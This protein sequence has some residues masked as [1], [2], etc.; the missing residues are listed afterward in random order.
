MNTPDTGDGALN[1]QTAALN[2]H[3]DVSNIDG[4]VPEVRRDVSNPHTASPEVRN[5]HVDPLMTTS[6]I[7]YSISKDREGADDRN[8]AVSTTYILPVTE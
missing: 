7:P 1:T 8:R 4:M 6:K 3:S 2:L 5:N